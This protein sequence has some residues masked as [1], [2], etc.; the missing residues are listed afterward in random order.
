MKKINF[1]FTLL[2]LG[3][4]LTGCVIYY[5]NFKTQKSG[6]KKIAIVSDVSISYDVQGKIDNVP[7]TENKE[8][9]KQAML[10]I[11]YEFE[12]KGYVV[13]KTVNLSIGLSF[14]N[15]EFN[16]VKNKEQTIKYNIKNP[17]YFINEIFK[18]EEDKQ[19][20]INFYNYFKTYTKKAK[21]SNKI[22]ED[23][24]P[25]AQKVDSESDVLA[26][27]IIRARDIPVLKQI[28][29]ALAS[30]ALSSAVTG[31]GYI[32]STY[33]STFVDLY[34]YLINAET[35]EI[36]W[37]NNHLL[38]D[39]KLSVRFFYSCAKKLMKKLMVKK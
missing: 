38:K 36:I 4:F 10:A 30:A 2:I 25:I 11:K 24:I 27:V 32:Y 23:A 15:E 14:V 3:I 7:I 34:I 5:P 33:P 37:R 20:L 13:G 35:G 17:P 31:A 9:A 12:K 21:E 19:N 8:F 39:G 26:V 6:I 22:L 16:I 28:G 18:E 29:I 1:L